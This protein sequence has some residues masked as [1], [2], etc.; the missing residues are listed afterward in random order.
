MIAWLGRC[1]EADWTLLP[2]PQPIFDLLH[3]QE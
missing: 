1:A 2:E 3:G